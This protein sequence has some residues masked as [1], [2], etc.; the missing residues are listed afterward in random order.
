LRAQ[1]RD[2]LT[3]AIEDVFVRLPSAEAVE[4]LEAAG[5]ANAR[6]NSVDEYLHHPQLA[7]TGS[8][9]EIASPGGHIR[10]LRPP[11]RLQA[12]EPVMGAVP[13]VGQHNDA[14]LQELGFGTEL[15]AKWKRDGVI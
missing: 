13:T 14:V 9:Y 8:W 4:R 7:A 11:A 5:I 15:I 2:A 1:H 12:V 10:A 6:V 3:S